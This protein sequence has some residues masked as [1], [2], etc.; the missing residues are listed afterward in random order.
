MATFGAATKAFGSE[1]FE[2]ATRA[3]FVPGTASASASAAHS[4]AWRAPYR[5]E[6]LLYWAWPGGRRGVKRDKHIF[7]G[8]YV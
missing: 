3:Y 8:T 5:I 6:L 4:C 1:G 2:E 7:S